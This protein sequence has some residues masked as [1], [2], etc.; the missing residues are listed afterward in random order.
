MIS[1]NA[2]SMNPFVAKG[3][4]DTVPSALITLMMGR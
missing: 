3:K 1:S 4:G 2:V